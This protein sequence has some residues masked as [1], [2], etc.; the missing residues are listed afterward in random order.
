MII[1]D[2]LSVYLKLD[3][4]LIVGEANLYTLG[5]LSLFFQEQSTTFGLTQCDLDAQALNKDPWDKKHYKETKERFRVYLDRYLKPERRIKGRRVYFDDHI[6]RD[7]FMEFQFH[8]WLC[9]AETATHIT[10]GLAYDD[11]VADCETV[12]ELNEVVEG[13]LTFK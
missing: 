5:I 2:Y 6:G 4:E 8:T 7:G 12:K 11:E 9:S 1:K 3:P 10:N 13:I